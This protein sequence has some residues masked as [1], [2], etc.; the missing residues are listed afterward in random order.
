M[1]QTAI[2]IIHK[3]IRMSLRSCFPGL[4]LWLAICVSLS[5]IEP[6]GK[7]R[8]GLEFSFAN[9][10]VIHIGSDTFYDF[11]V[12]VRGSVAGERIGTGILL[13]NYNPAV[14]GTYVH[15][16]GNSIVTRGSLI[17]T[18]PFPY[19]G[20]TVNDNASTRLAI[21]FEY[22]MAPGWGSSLTLIPQQIMHIRLRIQSYG[23]SVD[24][25]FAQAFMANQQFKDDNAT[26][27]SPVIATDTD[28]EYLPLAPSSLSISHL[29]DIIQLSWQ[30]QANCH[31][32]VYFNAN[33]SAT[34]W[35]LV[36]A[37]VAGNLWNS[38][39]GLPA[40]FF[41]VTAISDQ[42]SE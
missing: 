34:E 10:Q 37:N 5:A 40:G 1:N 11:D 32:N 12:M 27:F 24:L 2:T 8:G 41:K 18:S 36:A 16:S 14:F 39:V 23:S 20:V 3:F 30:V 33:P 35:Q 6:G 19:Y 26:L 9:S 25:S 38:P 21:T 15:G 7:S 22:I 29:D 13:I 42:R 31:Y 17:N 28:S 4:I